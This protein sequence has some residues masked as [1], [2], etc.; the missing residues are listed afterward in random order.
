[1]AFSVCWPGIKKNEKKKFKEEFQEKI[2]TS[3]NQILTIEVLLRRARN[4]VVLRGSGA[5]FSLG[6]T[7]FE[8]SDDPLGVQDGGASNSALGKKGNEKGKEGED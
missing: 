6:L 1:M 4:Q 2:Q 5:I 7:F 8:G 3:H